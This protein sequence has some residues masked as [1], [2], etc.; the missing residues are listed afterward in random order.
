[1][2]DGEVREG[3]TE[4]LGGCWTEMLVRVGRMNAWMGELAV[5]LTKGGAGQCEL[6]TRSL[7]TGG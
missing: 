7:A 1:M 6:P 5:A 2:L 4:M 3:W